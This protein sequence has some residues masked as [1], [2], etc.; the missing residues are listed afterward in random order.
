LSARLVLATVLEDERPVEED[1]VIEVVRTAAP[2]VRLGFERLSGRPTDELLALA[3]GLEA[4]LVVVG[5]RG[6]GAMKQALL[7]SVCG[8][9]VEETDLP[10][11]VVSP[12]A[13]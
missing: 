11:M 2:D 1:A 6:R 4:W 7:G 10:V 13:G 8:R 12:G 3:R 9:L 5:S